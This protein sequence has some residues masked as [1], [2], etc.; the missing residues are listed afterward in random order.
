MRSTAGNQALY[1]YKAKPPN[2]KR[3]KYRKN[4]LIMN[5]GKEF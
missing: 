5:I 2:E 3:E 1:Y 4:K